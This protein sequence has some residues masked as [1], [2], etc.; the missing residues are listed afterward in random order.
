VARPDWH[1]REGLEIT[2]FIDE[3]VTGA[4]GSFSA[5]HGIGQMQRGKLELP[6]PPGDFAA[7]RA[8]KKVHDPKGDHE[9]REIG[10][11]TFGT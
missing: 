2:R 8:I 10:R 3:L 9:P 1:K 4:S 11:L 7:L 5:E 6:A